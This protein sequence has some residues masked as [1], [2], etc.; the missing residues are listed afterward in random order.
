MRPFRILFLSACLSAFLLT[1]AADAQTFAPDLI[2][3]NATI[4]TMDEAHPS[5]EAVAISGE[6]IIAV[7]ASDAIRK[8]AGPRTRRIDAKRA[9]VLPGFNDSHVHF[10]SGGFQLSSVD[11]RDASSP[12]EFAERIRAFSEK[13]PRGRWIT[14]GDWDHER[15]EGAPLP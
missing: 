2:I 11:L 15:W 1:C 9:L 10:L 7:G 13:Y 14:G 8:L 6:R 5:A 12:E 3:V 4:H